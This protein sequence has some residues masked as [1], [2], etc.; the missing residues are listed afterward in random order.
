MS[1]L[2]NRAKES[3]ATTG[4]GTVNLGGAVAPF[5]TWAAAGA[6]TGRR[7]NYMIEDGTAWEIG[8]GVFTGASPDTLTR[9]LVASSTGSLLSLSGSASVSCVANKANYPV[10]FVEPVAAD[11]S[12]SR[13]A[14]GSPSI[15]DPAGQNGI[16]YSITRGAS[17]QHS[18]ALKSA[19]ISA[20]FTVEALIYIDYAVDDPFWWAGIAVGDTSANQHAF[21]SFMS[22]ATGITGPSIQS[23]YLSSLTASET[24]TALMVG[25]LRTT[26]LVKIEVTSTQVICYFSPDGEGRH[27]HIFSTIT[28][29]GNFTNGVTMVGFHHG[30]VSTTGTGRLWCPH[31]KVDAA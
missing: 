23:G 31:F 6:L 8:E 15:A 3:T 7:Y 12:T 18:F 26:M 27:W 11:F 5:Q 13:S 2:L 14:G 17:R 30:Y 20:P 25:A 16:F 10:Q 22:N 24:L 4:T 28:I 19:G 9:N 21:M 29:S 1:L